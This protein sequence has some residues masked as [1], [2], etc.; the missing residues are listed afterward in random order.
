MAV[1]TKASIKAAMS[2]IGTM[3]MAKKRMARAEAVLIFASDFCSI[4]FSTQIAEHE[5]DGRAEKYRG[6]FDDTVGQDAQ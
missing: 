2:N 3:T 1:V 5:A 4:R 6:E